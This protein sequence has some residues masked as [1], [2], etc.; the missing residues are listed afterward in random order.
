[1]LH[2]KQQRASSAFQEKMLVGLQKN[3]LLVSAIVIL[4]G[5]GLSLVYVNLDLRESI[6][7]L[8]DVRD[9]ELQKLIIEERDKVKRDLEELY[10]ADMVSYKAMRKRMAVEKER[11]KDRLQEL[12]KEVE[13]LKSYGR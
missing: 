6:K 5:V 1:M 7:E 13:E 12:Q 10:R 9:A 4:F 11:S 8:N 3:I 2:E